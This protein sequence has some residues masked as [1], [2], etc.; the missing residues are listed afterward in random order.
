MDLREFVLRF[1]DERD[2]MFACYTAPEPTTYVGRLLREA[3]L[4]DTQHEK[5]VAALGQALTDA[6]YTILLGLDG[7][8]AI[9]GIQQDYRI[10]DETGAMISKGNGELEAL[11][12]ELF[13]DLS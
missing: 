12:S 8:A 6:F 10:Q 1:R 9:G 13:Q 11:A 7:S 3:E 2:A 5:V 4:N